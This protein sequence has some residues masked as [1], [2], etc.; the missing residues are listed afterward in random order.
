MN[1]ILRLVMFFTL[2]IGAEKTTACSVAGTITSNRDSVCYQDTIT[3]TTT[4][5]TGTVFQWQSDNGGGWVNEAGAGATTDTYTFVP[6]ET[7]QYR[8]IVTAT[9]CPADTSAILTVTVGAIPVPTGTGASR[10]GY[11][12][13]TLTGTGSAGGSLRWFTAPSGGIPI[14]TGNSV[15]VTVGA[16]TTFYLEDNTSGGGGG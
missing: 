10:C 13:L 7:K 6:G 2:I 4:G 11:G 3:L 5:Y 15:N 1:R 9:G 14:G 12:Q 8:I 16:T